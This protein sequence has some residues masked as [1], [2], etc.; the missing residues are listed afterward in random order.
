MS[1]DLKNLKQLIIANLDKIERVSAPTEE[2]L[3]VKVDK[4]E[5]EGWV[6][7]LG[8]DVGVF[9]F[10]RSNGEVLWSTETHSQNMVRDK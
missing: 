1:K 6:S 10:K 4:M 2:E 9:K 8:R 5:S 3:K 7:I